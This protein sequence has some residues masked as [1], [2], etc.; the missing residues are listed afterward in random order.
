MASPTCTSH[1]CHV[2]PPELWPSV[3]K[4]SSWVLGG[5]IRTWLGGGCVQLLLTQTWRRH[6]VT[7]A[8]DLVTEAAWSRGQELQPTRCCPETVGV[9]L[10]TPEAEP[11]W[12][13]GA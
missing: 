3:H 5:S 8:S 9:G 1:A 12:E 13:L 7:W 6:R 11:L 2:C 10:R 4:H